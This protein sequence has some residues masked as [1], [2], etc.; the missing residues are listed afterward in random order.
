MEDKLR[1]IINVAGDYVEKKKF[2]T[3][4]AMSKLVES[5]YK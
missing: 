3:K 1:P 2:S 4:L 5:A